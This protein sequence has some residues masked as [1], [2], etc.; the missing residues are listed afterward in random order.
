MIIHP[1]YVG[2]LGKGHPSLCCDL[3]RELLARHVKVCSDGMCRFGLHQAEILHTF[4]NLSFSFLSPGHMTEETT[5]GL[6]EIYQ[7]R[8]LISND[9]IL[10]FL[11]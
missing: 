4:H 1:G 7:S 9:A 11:D 10:S 5:E 8:L 3:L 6:L 2:G